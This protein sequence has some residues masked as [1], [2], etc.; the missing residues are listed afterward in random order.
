MVSRHERHLNSGRIRK[1]L[2]DRYDNIKT[3]A[4]LVKVLSTQEQGNLD[5]DASRAAET[6]DTSIKEAV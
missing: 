1:T 2:E 5:V 6:Q 3:D 4:L